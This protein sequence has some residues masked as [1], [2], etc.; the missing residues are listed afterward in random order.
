MRIERR[1]TLRDAEAHSRRHTTPLEQPIQQNALTQAG[2]WQRQDVVRDR[3]E[4]EQPLIL[5]TGD[6]D[7][8]QVVFQPLEQS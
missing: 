6:G 5:V 8:G 2:R 1:A 7:V 4:S 3:Y